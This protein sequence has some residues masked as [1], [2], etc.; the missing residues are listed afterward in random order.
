MET[1]HCVGLE[2]VS[3]FPPF[4]LVKQHCKTGAKKLFKVSLLSLPKDSL[5]NRVLKC[6]VIKMK[7]LKLW[8]LSGYSERTCPRG[9]LAK[10]EHLGANCL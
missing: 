4:V 9:L 6:D 2:V 1:G 3:I 5:V 7:F 8:D 10:N